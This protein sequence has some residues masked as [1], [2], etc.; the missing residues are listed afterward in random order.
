M[1]VTPSVG[2]RPSS[3]DEFEPAN[4]YL[5]QAER[6]SRLVLGEEV[7]S[8]PLENARD[9]AATIDALVASTR[10]DTWCPL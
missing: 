1:S 8:W 7:P 4:H 10:G 9:I 6:F 3:S 2:D 5:L